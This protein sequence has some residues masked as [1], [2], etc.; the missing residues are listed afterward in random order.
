[1]KAGRHIPF[2]PK[3]SDL[4]E[5]QYGFTLLELLVVLVL[6]GIIAAIV[7]LSIGVAQKKTQLRDAARRAYLQIRH[8]REVAVLEKK[9]VS[10]SISDEGDAYT[11]RSG[12]ESKEAELQTGDDNGKRPAGNSDILYQ[13]KM[14]TGINISGK[15][16]VFYPR[17]DSTGGKLLITDRDG[18]S[19][20]IMVDEFSG[21]VRL[22]RGNDLS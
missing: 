10:L 3:Q 15:T 7:S 6:V 14:P 20:M 12:T 19:Y 22:K 13:V 18:R 2:L 11:I 9:Y 5:K 16:I 21:K 1:M 4:A 17:G 8:A